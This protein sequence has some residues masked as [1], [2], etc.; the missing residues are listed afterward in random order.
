MADAQTWDAAKQ[1]RILDRL[2]FAKVVSRLRGFLETYEDL[3]FSSRTFQLK[4]V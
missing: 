3:I 2:L 4:Y 1:C